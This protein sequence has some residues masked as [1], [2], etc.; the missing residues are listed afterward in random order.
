MKK[1][2]FSI[3]STEFK[4]VKNIKSFF[5]TSFEV[6]I[7]LSLS[8]VFNQLSLSLSLP[9]IEEKKKIFSFSLSL[10]SPPK[11][12]VFQI[13]INRESFRK[14]KEKKENILFLSLSLSRANKT[15]FQTAVYILR[16]ENRSSKTFSFNFFLPS[17]RSFST[18][19]RKGFKKGFLSSLKT[20][21]LKSLATIRRS[22]S[23]L[24]T[25]SYQVSG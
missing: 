9:E 16:Y 19:F 21:F 12:I 14:I 3:F 1:I 24:K 8:F 11:T 7:R 20:S 17:W 4:I 5:Q 13:S 6:S 18:R 25:S 15:L 22:D 23:L 2:S 10:S